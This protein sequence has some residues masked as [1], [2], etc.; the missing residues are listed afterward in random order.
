MK[1]KHQQLLS[2]VSI[3]AYWCATYTWDIINYMLPCIAAIILI[4][5]FN[6]KDLV[7]NGAMGATICLFLAYGT[8]VASFTY[9]LTYLFTSHST[10]QIMTLVINLL[11]VILLL[12]SFVMQQID[13]TCPADSALRFVYRLMPGFSLGNGL[14]QL[15]LISE[16]PYLET[17]CGKLSLIQRVE[18]HFAPFDPLVAGYPLLYMVL[19]SVFYFLAAIGID[20]LLSYPVI[21]SRLIPDKNVPNPPYEEDS[22]VVRRTHAQAHACTHARTNTRTCV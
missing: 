15:S 2:G 5:A 13:S 3:P 1:A 6:I 19:Q 20:I 16:L 7:Q 11:C 9:L 22:D 17:N 10:A 21:K 18:Q 12:A 14:L 4:A 8:S